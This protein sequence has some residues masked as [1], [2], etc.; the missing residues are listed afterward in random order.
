MGLEFMGEVG[1]LLVYI[2]QL[3]KYRLKAMDLK[4]VTFKVSRERGEGALKCT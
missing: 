3:G 2:S 4:T 1:E